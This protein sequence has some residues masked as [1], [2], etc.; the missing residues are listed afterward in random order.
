MTIINQLIAEKLYDPIEEVQRTPS[1]VY[2]LK[3]IGVVLSGQ[4]TTSQI[5]VQNPISGTIA[6]S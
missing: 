2:L 6:L 5:T 4:A 3:R 1:N